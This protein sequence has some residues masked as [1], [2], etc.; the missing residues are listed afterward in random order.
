[1]IRYLTIIRQ[2]AELFKLTQ[3]CH[4]DCLVVMLQKYDITKSI[5]LLLLAAAGGLTFGAS[6]QSITPCTPADGYATGLSTY[7]QEAEA[8]LRGAVTI[9]ENFEAELLTR[10]NTARDA[11]GLA[12]LHIR[13][14]F[15]KA[16]RAHALDMAERSYVDHSDPEGRDHL[17]RMRAIDR[18]TLIG[19]S[20]A[21]VLKTSNGNDAGDLFVL[22]QED[23]QN[24]SNIMSDAFTHAGFGIVRTSDGIH[25]TIVFASVRGELKSPMPLTFA[26]FTSVRT[27]LFD[28]DSEQVAWGLTDEAS[29]ELL[30]KGKA[31]RIAAKRIAGVE[32]A[33]LDVV[34]EDSRA[35][36]ALKGPLV[37][38][39]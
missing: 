37:S 21:A 20:G 2:T 27:A 23:P 18:Q 25:L 5:S 9:E 14:G 13:E 33:A 35:T 29:G 36:Y 6:A 11:Q 34:I 26:G 38:A 1:M 8:C 31:G 24:N 16:A 10:I 4:A 17:F 39:R 3:K 32:M 30:A 22:M 7:V 19:A 15:T 28:S 12:P